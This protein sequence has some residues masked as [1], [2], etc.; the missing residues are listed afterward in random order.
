MT[1]LKNTFISKVFFYFY[2]CM[3]VY[4]CKTITFCVATHSP[5]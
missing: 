4:V 1:H 5:A 3:Y 2:E